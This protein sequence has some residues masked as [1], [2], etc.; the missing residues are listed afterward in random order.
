MIK[1]NGHAPDAINP[2]I[3][4]GR[5][6]KGIQ[7]LKKEQKI[8]LIITNIIPPP[9][10]LGKLCELLLFGLYN[11]NFFITGIINLNK[12]SVRKKTKKLTRNIFINNYFS[13]EIIS[14]LY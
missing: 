12:N 11:T 10:G 8:T 5:Q 7:N 2:N 13:G 3:A 6:I 14:F 9:L 4:K 1:I